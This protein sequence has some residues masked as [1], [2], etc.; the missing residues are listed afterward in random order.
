MANDLKIVGELRGIQQSDEE[1]GLFVFG[2][3]ADQ[4]YA[5]LQSMPVKAPILQNA[6]IAFKRKDAEK[7]PREV[8]LPRSG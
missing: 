7:L 6:R 2:P 8:R 5:T 3:S 1:T 4:I